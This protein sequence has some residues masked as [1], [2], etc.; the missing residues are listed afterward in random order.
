[1]KINGTITIDTPNG[2]MIL[3]GDDLQQDTYTTGKEIELSWDDGESDIKKVF[4]GAP[5]AGDGDW[6]S[7]NCSIVSDSIDIDYLG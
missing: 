1:M 3:Q 2:Q 4:G 7:N 6:E 5:E